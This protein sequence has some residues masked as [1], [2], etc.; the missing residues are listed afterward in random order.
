MIVKKITQGW[1]IQE[2]N[3]KTGKLVSQYFQAGDEIEW[4]NDKHVTINNMDLYAPFSMI[5]SQPETNSKRMLM[6]ILGL[7][8]IPYA[9][10]YIALWIENYIKW[11]W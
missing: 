3:I 2:F 8:T 11:G 6:L 5:Q 9:G 4:E 10:M 1:V 7:V